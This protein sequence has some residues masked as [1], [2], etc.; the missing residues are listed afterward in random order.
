MEAEFDMLDKN[1]SYGMYGTA[2][3]RRNVPSTAKNVRPIW[4][5]SQKGNGVHKAR[6]CMDGKQLVRMG[7]KFTNTYA[8]CMEQHCLRLFMAI[9]AYMG[10]IIE[11]GDV[12][13][14]YAHAAAEGT[15]IYI[16]EDAVF[17]S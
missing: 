14:A 8:S 5:Y 17:Q 15:Q 13:N 11:D 2:V 7:V 10:H 16:A 4:N 9:A 6:K 1:D 12:V 3:K